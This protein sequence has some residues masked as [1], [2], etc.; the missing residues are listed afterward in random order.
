MM[1]EEWAN[2]WDGVGWFFSGRKKPG[3]TGEYTFAKRH[4]TWVKKNFKQVFTRFDLYGPAA[5]LKK[6]LDMFNAWQDYR[7][8]TDTQCD[9]LHPC[10]KHLDVILKNSAAFAETVASAQDAHSAWALRTILLEGLAMLY[11]QMS[12]V[13]LCAFRAGA[14]RR[15][16]HF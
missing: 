15:S 4:E 10:S 2:T 8:Q 12:D 6:V 5:D 13:R 7:S 14:V 1:A 9:Y 16:L 3:V 11:P